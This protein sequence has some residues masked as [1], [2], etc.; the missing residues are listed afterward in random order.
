MAYDDKTRV[1]HD[2]DDGD[3][4]RST[5][6]LPAPGSTDYKPG[7]MGGEGTRGDAAGAS[8]FSDDK[9]N[10]FKNAD[11]SQRN[12]NA[13]ATPDFN[14]ILK[15]A[16]DG[17]TPKKNFDKM[18]RDNKL[19]TIVITLVAA[20]IVCSLAFFVVMKMMEAKNNYGA[21]VSESST[22]A[23][24]TP[25]PEST[26]TTSGSDNDVTETNPTRANTSI[27]GTSPDD[28]LASVDGATIVLSA[29]N[30]RIHGISVSNA[31]D[32][33]I[34]GVDTKCDMKTHN[35]NCYLGT[36]TVDDDTM[37]IYAFNDAK[38]NT[39]LYSDSDPETVTI[40]GA[41]MS[42]ITPMT[43]NGANQNALVIVM[44][45]QTGVILTSANSDK[46]KALVDENELS[47]S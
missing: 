36:V 29:N 26:A 4:A 25:V 15:G 9:G 18:E 27:T 22:T 43:V 41:A 21:Q 12:V 7:F 33:K 20:I 3:G 32:D 11:G 17:Y 1:V 19:K 6:P 30:A 14:D 39:L 45:D 28:V 44:N 47:I 8:P 40:Q 16:G 23:P 34:T 31:K 38:T 46:L 13:Y 42:Y 35:T 5:A 37:G 24:V 10:P 2:G